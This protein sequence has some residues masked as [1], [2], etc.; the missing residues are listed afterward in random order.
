MK[1]II[2]AILIIVC[3]ALLLS[4][5][6]KRD[7]AVY[8]EGYSLQIQKFLTIQ[9]SLRQFILNRNLHSASDVKQINEEIEGA[10][11]QLKA[12][13]FWLRYLDPIAYKKINGPLPV[14]WE[15]EV[16]EKFEKP[17][18]RE[19]AGLTLAALYLEDSLV[20]KDSLIQLINY[21]IEATRV[22]EEDSITSRLK[23]Y[24]H[25]Y[26]CNRLYL[27]NL[28][29]IYT[30]GF[31]CPDTA[32]IIPEL[33]RMVNNVDN[34]YRSFNE[35]FP[36]TALNENY[37]LLYKK[38]VTFTGEQPEEY[39]RFDNYTFIREFIN[40]LFAINQQLI[41]EYKVY[42]TSMMDYSLNK[43]NNSIFDIELYT[44]QNAKGIFL[45][46]KDD[47][48]LAEIDRIGKLL[49][50]DPVLSGNN[51]RSC[52]SCHKPTEYFTD[53]TVAAA[54]SFNHKEFLTR[55]TPS[56]INAGYNH[57]IMLDGKH[58]SLQNQASEVITNPLEMGAAGKQVLQ[59][60]LSCPDYKKTFKKLLQYTPQE[61][62]ITFNHIISAITFY[63]SKFSKQYAPFDEA[64]NKKADLSMEEKKGFNLFMSKAQCATCHFVPQ[65]NGVKPPYVGSEFE[66]LGVPE[67]T[68]YLKLSDDNGRYNVNPAKETLHA[69]RTGSV[70]N[71][72]HT[73]PYMH[74]GVF[75]S[76]EQV[77]DFY[78]AG[79][80]AGKGLSVENQTLS[81][82][83]LKLSKQEKAQ[84]LA[85]IN[86][87]NEK[88][89]FEKAPAKL[90]ASTNKMLNRRKPGGE[91]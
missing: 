84:L 10:R 60:I 73:K 29:S 48:V 52:A 42:S 88:V 66:V 46:V 85:F 15:T 3:S 49:F 87:L 14:E 74:N 2:T 35:N 83:S 37:N 75:T 9:Q 58:I 56:L 39:S 91:Y 5:F 26:L 19:G 1:K 51:Q 33:K 40:P 90:P 18:K 6:I 89:A 79:G 82:D 17:Y 77:I 45:R 43:K 71:S 12:V 38:L 7:T 23:D 70:R 21:S 59:K 53:T 72:A 69:F 55:N 44:G 20:E 24:H 28:A 31:E 4:S 61:T 36:N 68:G 47:K 81:S 67:D 22:F 64:M 25:F 63:Y 8:T 50:Y 80:G 54:F 11:L 30:T 76:M 16:F 27:L 62:E 34:I 32:R 78:D 41:N 57:L 13:D 65:F 86:A